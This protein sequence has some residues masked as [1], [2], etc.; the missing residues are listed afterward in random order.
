MSEYTLPDLSY[1]YGAL[2]P[3]QQAGPGAPDT[4]LREVP[5]PSPPRAPWF[6]ALDDATKPG[7]PARPG[8]PDERHPNTDRRPN[9]ERKSIST[10]YLSKNGEHRNLGMKTHSPAPSRPII[11]DR[12]LFPF[13]AILVVIEPGAFADAPE[14]FGRPDRARQRGR[15]RIAVSRH[16]PAPHTSRSTL[17]P[18]KHKPI[19]YLNPPF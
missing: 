14:I 5:R 15:S 10:V 7:T 16:A 1:D 13:D 3:T 11:V 8:V 4:D 17:D 2:E 6:N 12:L 19:H 9:P 18:Q